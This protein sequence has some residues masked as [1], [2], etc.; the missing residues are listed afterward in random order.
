MIAMA[1]ESCQVLILPD[2][3][4]DVINLLLE[5]TVINIG[6]QTLNLIEASST[7]LRLKGR[8]EHRPTTGS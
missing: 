8:S 3:A 6:D 5:V 4:T 2:T 7:N 1:H